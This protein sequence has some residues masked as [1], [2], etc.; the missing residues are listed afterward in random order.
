MKGGIKTPELA[1]GIAT[2]AKSDMVRI[3]RAMLKDPHWAQKAI[4][5]LK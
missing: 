3:G 1:N 4:E 5:K 2:Q